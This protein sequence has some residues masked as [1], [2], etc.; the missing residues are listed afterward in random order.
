MTILIAAAGTGGHVFPGLAVGEALVALGVAQDS[1]VFV[2]GRRLEAEVYPTAGFPFIPLQLAGLTRSFALSNLALPAVVRRAARAVARILDERS[3]ASV[4]G[5]GGYVTVPVALALRRRSVPL[6]LAEQNAQA[7]LA[8]RFCSRWAKRV[9]TSFPHT[10][11]LKRQEWVG[12]PIR[13][14]LSAFNRSVLRPTA[15]QH[16]G[17]A[18]D[19][20]VVGVMGGSLGAALLNRVA[21]QLADTKP[22]YTILNLAGLAHANEQERLA[23]AAASPW[24]VR[25]F[26]TRIE[27]FYAAIDVVVARAGGVVAEYTATATPAILIPGGFGSGEHQ[28]ANAR[29]VAKTGAAIVVSED[30]LERVPA[31]VQAALGQRAEMA[32]ATATLARPQAA[33]DIAEALLQEAGP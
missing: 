28:W 21:Q 6:F 3:V 15:R 29:A 24:I 14:S 22:A 2:G 8:N 5:L 11:G 20:T 33:L 1:V 25:G 31:L 12:N 18:D 30:E 17:I 4:L 23:A 7:G 13:A 32:A 26:E 9:F 10:A 27:L 16:F 19:Q